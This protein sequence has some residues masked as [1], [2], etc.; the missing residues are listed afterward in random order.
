MAER[1]ALPPSYL[2]V[3]LVALV[4]I[5]LFALWATRFEAPWMLGFAGWFLAAQIYAPYRVF[6]DAKERGDRSR[7][8]RWTVA[9]AASALLGLVFAVLVWT[10]LAV[11][12]PAAAIGLY[13]LA[14]R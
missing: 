9:V 10:P 13:A 5:P 14:R 2:I 7:A 11:L 8:V 4:G 1:R 3:G 12:L 6:A